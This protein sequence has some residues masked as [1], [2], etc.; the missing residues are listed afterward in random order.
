[1]VLVD[2]SVWI[3]HLRETEPLL[4]SL[5]LAETVVCHPFII[6]ELACGGL[7][8]RPEILEHLQ[9]LPQAPEVGHQEILTFIDARCLMGRGIGLVDVHLLAAAVLHGDHL[10]TQDQRLRAV[11]VE[12]G[13][14]FD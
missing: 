4:Q 13:I 5:L 10:L 1:M 8:N 9:A 6:G 11:A 2:T 7:G 14:S 3:S 12:L